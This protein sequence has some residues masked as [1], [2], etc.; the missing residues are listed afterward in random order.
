VHAVVTD[1]GLRLETELLPL[2]KNLPSQGLGRGLGRVCWTQHL[3]SKVRPREILRVPLHGVVVDLCS[4]LGELRSHRHEEPI[5]D[6]HGLL[7]I[8]FYE[9]AV[10]AATQ[11]NQLLG[12]LGLGPLGVHRVG[13]YAEVRATVHGVEDLSGGQRIRP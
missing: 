2:G 11:L 9:A 12:I 7:A 3:A 13:V 6:V 5:E 10:E 4:R 1:I 8:Y